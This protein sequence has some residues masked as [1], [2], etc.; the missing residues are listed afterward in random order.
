MTTPQPY[1]KNRILESWLAAGYVNFLSAAAV[2]EELPEQ[3]REAPLDPLP[4]P[5]SGVPISPGNRNM[6]RHG[7]ETL[8]ENTSTT[9]QSI[10]Y[11]GIQVRQSQLPNRYQA[12]MITHR[13]KLPKTMKRGRKLHDR[14]RK[15]HPHR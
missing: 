7:T 1:A 3:P 12:T 15:S 11:H 14:A 2:P 5:L 4:L 8:Y 10:A 9:T 13:I 6:T